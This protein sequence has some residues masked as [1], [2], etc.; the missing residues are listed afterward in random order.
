MIKTQE[1]KDYIIKYVNDPEN[2]DKKFSIIIKE[3]QK[4]FPHLKNENE[5]RMLMIESLVK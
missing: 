4:K 2:L 3:I 1:E 5:I